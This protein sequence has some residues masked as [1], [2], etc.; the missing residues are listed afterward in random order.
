M[1]REAFPHQHTEHSVVVVLTNEEAVLPPQRPF[2]WTGPTT[3]CPHHEGHTAWPSFVRA[4]SERA[5]FPEPGHRCN[6]VYVKSSQGTTLRDGKFPEFWSRL[7]QLTGNARVH[8]GAYHFLS[9]AGSGEDQARTFMKVLT[10]NA[11]LQATD[12]PPVLDLEWD[13]VRQGAPD[14]WIGQDPDLIIR[15]VLAWLQF[16]ENATYRTPMVYTA[17]AWW[18]ER[19]GS[20]NKFSQLDRYKVWIADYSRSSQAVEIPK[21]PNGAEAALWQFTES[22]KLAGGFIGAI[23]A[24]VYKYKSPDTVANSILILTSTILMIIVNK[25]RALYGEGVTRVTE[26]QGMAA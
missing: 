2:R 17:R 15:K 20:E 19:I 7:G 10:D 11:G 24:N 5:A 8:R 1:R 4:K 3:T 23:D 18:R 14:R 26:G 13:I 6:F 16:V 22:A 12:M 25:P 21:V 9:S